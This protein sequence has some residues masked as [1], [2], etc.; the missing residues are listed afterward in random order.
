MLKLAPRLYLSSKPY[1]LAVA[2]FDS[3][4]I[5]LSFATV[6]GARSYEYSLSTTSATAGYGAWTAL[7][8]NKIIAGLSQGTQYWIRVRTVNSMARGPA[9]QP[10]TA[11]TDAT[12][13]TFDDTKLGASG[14]VLSNGDLT[15]TANATQFDIAQVAATAS[16]EAG[17]PGKYYFEGQYTTMF[18]EGFCSLN[19]RQSHTSSS[20]SNIEY[21]WSGA[22]HC[23][24]GGATDTIQPA[25][26]DDWVGFAVDSDL[27]KIW[28]INVTQ[29]S[30]WNDDVI[31]N[32]DPA[33]GIG[34]IDMHAGGSVDGI[35]H[36]PGMA[37]VIDDDVCNVKFS[38]PFEGTAP[39]GFTGI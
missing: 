7:A 38:A 30:G 18:H 21:L 12:G 37:C 11:T 26:Q 17:Q 1:N 22:V 3:V 25:I 29:A 5:T 32:Q 2:A 23:N 15:A 6:I 8:A 13:A 31:G 27:G 36:F 34:G 14:I 10:V 4:S 19:L 20:T 35:V 24:S 16:F 39:S 28:I 33:N 9:S